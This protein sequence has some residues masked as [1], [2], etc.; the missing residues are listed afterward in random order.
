V[1]L[2]RALLS[3]LRAA[4]LVAFAAL[5]WPYVYMPYLA[6]LRAQLADPD[7]TLMPPLALADP[8]AVPYRRDLVVVQEPHDQLAGTAVQPGCETSRHQGR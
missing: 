5:G 4:Y 2:V 7:A 1:D 6:L 3:W 8:A